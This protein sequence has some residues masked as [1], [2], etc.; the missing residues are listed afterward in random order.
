MEGKEKGNKEDEG[1]EVWEY[2]RKEDENGRTKV[3]GKYMVVTKKK[4]RKTKVGN[5]EKRT[6]G[7]GKRK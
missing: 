3:Y 6:R 4:N 1:K 2:K 5:G 7:E